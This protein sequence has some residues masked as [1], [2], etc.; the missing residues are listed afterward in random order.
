MGSIDGE[1]TF[2]GI[3][4][5]AV[6]PHGTV[7][8]T[9]ALLPEVSVFTPEGHQLPPVGRAGQGPGEFE[10]GA[11]SVGWRADTL[12]A[13]DVY[14]TNFF[15]PEGDPLRQVRFS[16][17][18]VEEGSRFGPGVPLADG[19]FL[20]GRGIIDWSQ[21]A[22]GN[23]A[24]A[25]RRFSETGEIVDTLA[26]VDWEGRFIDVARD[27]GSVIHQRHPMKLRQFED[28]SATARATTPDGEAV[29]LVRDGDAGP[30]G[31]HFSL[32]KVASSGDTLLH[33]AI[34]YEPIP[35]TA[36]EEDWW[37]EAFAAW[38]AGDFGANQPGTAQRPPP[39]MERMRRE[40]GAAFWAPD[41]HPPVRDVLAGQDG[42]IR[43]LRE[44]TGERL[45]RWEV[46]DSAG[47][48]IGVV[49]IDEGRSSTIP[50]SSRV[51]LLHA[52]LDDVW[53]VTIDDFD[54]PY[55][56]RFQVHRDC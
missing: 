3:H 9:E 54:V 42:T 5:V 26:F 36:S 2:S 39:V 18:V 16:V 20:G 44:L 1:V 25:I 12:W 4:D 28:P 50:W 6:G 53:G 29:V 37:R 56:H 21:Y 13:H 8:V 46:Y 33:R 24:L 45:A 14:K 19:T 40:A 38:H 23:D 52:G 48:L 55:L 51:K 15:D 47:E 22:V 41:R 7:Y 17:E 35:V 34:P 27:D 30:G 49:A 11:R 32:V 31:E 43:L 10:W